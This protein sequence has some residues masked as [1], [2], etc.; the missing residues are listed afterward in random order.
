MVCRVTDVAELAKKSSVAWLQAHGRRWPIWHEWVDD[1]NGGAVC[2]V[3]SVGGGSEQPIP[4]VVDGET[5]TLLLRGKA[6]RAL[7][8]S[9]EARVEIIGA[10]SAAWEPTTAALKAGRLN[11]DD[12]SSAVDRW[13][14]ECRVLRLVPVEATPAGELAD[15]RAQTRPHLS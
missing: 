3:G 1:E 2:V 14:R 5:V 6:D 9:V 15:D 4:D 12:M 11:L 7:A 13:A 8:A 10:G